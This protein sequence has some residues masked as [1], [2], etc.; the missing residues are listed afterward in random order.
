MGQRFQYFNEYVDDG[1]YDDKI[2]RE[3]ISNFEEWI[4]HHKDYDKN[5]IFRTRV[6]DGK[7]KS[8]TYSGNLHINIQ[9]LFTFSLT[10]K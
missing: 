4:E 10:F 3:S 8:K 2:V 1:F 9:E 7:I 5:T 6:S